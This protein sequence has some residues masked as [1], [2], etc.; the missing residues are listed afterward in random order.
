MPAGYLPAMHLLPCPD[1]SYNLF[2][3]LGA[4]VRMHG[5]VAVAVETNAKG[6]SVAAP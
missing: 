6:I 1:R 4:V 2:D 3:S 5:G